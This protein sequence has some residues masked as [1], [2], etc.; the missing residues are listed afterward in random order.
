V[1]IGPDGR[2]SD[3]SQVHSFV[4]AAFGQQP[5]KFTIRNVTLR[6][7]AAVG[8]YEEWQAADANLTGRISTAVLTPK[9]DMPNGL[10]WMHLHETWLPDARP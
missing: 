10:Q 2:W 5:T 9:S 3:A 8:T 7:D 4:R 1:R 6:G